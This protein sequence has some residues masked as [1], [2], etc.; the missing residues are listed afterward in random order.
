MNALGFALAM[1]AAIQSTPTHKVTCR[2]LI[3]G[4]GYVCSYT[5]HKHTTK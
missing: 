4:S 1:I 2:T 5:T 3:Q